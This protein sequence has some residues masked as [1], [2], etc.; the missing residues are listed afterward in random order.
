MCVD[1]KGLHGEVHGLEQIDVL[2][3][4]I[5]DD[6][7]DPVVFRPDS[8][9]GVAGITAAIRAGNVSVA[10]GIGTGIADDKAIFALHAGDRAR[11]YLNEGARC[12]RSSRRTS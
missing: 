2:Y 4:R 11:Y 12:C 6:F 10:N 7:L 3:R 1:H 9:L 5:D 8:L